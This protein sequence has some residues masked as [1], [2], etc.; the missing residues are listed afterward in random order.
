MK[1]IL[2]GT[3]ALIAAGIIAS[4]AMALPSVKLTGNVDFRAGFA[5]IDGGDGEEDDDFGDFGSQG[6]FQFDMVETLENGL[7]YGGKLDFDFDSGDVVMDEAMIFLSGSFGRVEL[8]DEDGASDTMAIYTPTVGIG[9][10]D[11]DASDFFGPANSIALLKTVDSGDSTK[12]TYYTPRFS[13]F[14]AG[15]SYAPRTD[16][17]D[18]YVEDSAIDDWFEAGLNYT[19]EF[20]TVSV[21][22]SFTFS[23][24]NPSRLLSDLGGDRFYGYQA[25]LNVGFGGFTVG[26]GVVWHDLDSGDQFSWNAGATYTFGAW[27]VGASV[28]QGEF[29]FDDGGNPEEWQVGVGGEYKVASGLTLAADVY[30]GNVDFDDG[31]DDQDYVVGILSTKVNF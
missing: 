18:S 16:G 23:S 6:D 31:G 12:I 13:G 20:D 2:M 3:T 27:G 29:D 25:G 26:G 19:G 28:A 11:G 24:G 1:K 7:I 9:Q 10:V 8:G 22:G 5:S 17:F 14:Q 21:A 15:V 4:P 30:F